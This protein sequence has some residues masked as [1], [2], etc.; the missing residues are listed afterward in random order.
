M[1][2]K[3]AEAVA[4][5]AVFI[6]RLAPG[7]TVKNTE[8]GPGN[9]SRHPTSLQGLSTRRLQPVQMIGCAFFCYELAQSVTFRLHE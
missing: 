3:A 5:V 4:E 1:E 9:A 6:L 7:T 8:V 2:A